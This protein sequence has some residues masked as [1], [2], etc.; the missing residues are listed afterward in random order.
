MRSTVIALATV[1]VLASGALAACGSSGTT[2]S[3]STIPTARLGSDGSDN[4][5]PA[6]GRYSGNSGY[7]R[8]SFTY[9][10]GQIRNLEL[11]KEA[12]LRVASAP[13]RSFV[14]HL[15]K[16]VIWRGRWYSPTYVEGVYEYFVHHDN[17]NQRQEIQWFAEL[18]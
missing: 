18:E 9:A 7:G 17:G 4:W 16:S 1:A 14:V 11:G 13:N 5:T 2:A 10:D 6:A 8:V 15:A 12:S 3:T